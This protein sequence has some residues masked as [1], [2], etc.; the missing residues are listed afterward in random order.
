MIPARSVAGSAKSETT[1]LPEPASDLA[2]T[3]VRPR[4]QASFRR[5]LNPAFPAVQL[6]DD[7]MQ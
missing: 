6:A 4:V 2:N 5:G 3:K 7:K 1:R